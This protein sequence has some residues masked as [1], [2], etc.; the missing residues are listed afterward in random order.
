MVKVALH[1][2][3]LTTEKFQNYETAKGGCGGCI[4]SNKKSSK[5][6]KQ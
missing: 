4:P 5:H 3:C 6:K 1:L 2:K